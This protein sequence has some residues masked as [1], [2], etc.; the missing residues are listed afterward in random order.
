MSATDYKRAPRN[1]PEEGS[2][3]VEFCS[4]FTIWR[5]FENLALFLLQMELEGVLCVRMKDHVLC[6]RDIT[7]L[8]SE[9]GNRP[10]FSNLELGNDKLVKITCRVFV[11]KYYFIMLLGIILSKNLKNIKFR[12]Y[13]TRGLEMNTLSCEWAREN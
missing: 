6:V 5:Y 13:E 2:P 11:K 3:Q 8:A 10:C 12:L 4:L 9:D 1:I 7:P